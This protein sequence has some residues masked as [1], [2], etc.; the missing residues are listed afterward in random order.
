MVSG[1]GTIR[2]GGNLPTRHGEPRATGGAQALALIL[3]LTLPITPLLSLAPNLPQLFTHFGSA[4]HAGILVPLIVTMPSICIALLSPISGLI[5]DKLGRR[6]MLLLASATF[7]IFAV[8]PFWLNSLTSVLASQFVVG[9]AE[10]FIMTCGNALLG[11][12]FAPEPRKRWLGVQAIV[13][14][15]LATAIL[16]TGGALGTLSWHA[17]FLTNILGVIVLVWLLLATWEP[18]SATRD[19]DDAPVASPHRFPWRSMLPVYALSLLTGVFYYFQI[20]MGVF[21][22]KF[23]VHS[24]FELSVLTTIVSVGVIAGG[25]YVH[26]QHG[27]GTAFNVALIYLTYGVGY[28]GIA[29]SPNF[30]VAM[31]FAVIAQVGNGLFIPTFVGWALATLD[32]AHR[33]RGMGLWMTSFFSAQFLAPTILTLVS[34]ARGRGLLAAVALAG[35]ASLAL[36]A[37]TVAKSS[38]CAAAPAVPR[39]DRAPARRSRP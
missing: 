20:E 3:A 15:V 31:P 16:L 13:G 6:R 17:P 12:Y 26:R 5:A 27:R 24:P 7:S 21:F 29:R 32:P 28:I 4:P 30:L 9:A 23:G 37:I 25:W 11:D 38:I 33:G 19:G 1:H 39:I 2:L 36:A 34:Q 35:I 10:A 18:P 22:S 8:L 14:S